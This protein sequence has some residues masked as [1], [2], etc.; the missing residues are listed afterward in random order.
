MFP[1]FMILPLWLIVAIAIPL[2]Q[3]L[4][5]LQ[6]KSAD[7]KTWLFYWICYVVATWLLYYF[8]WLI[9]IPFYVLS[10]YIDLYYEAQILLVL[11]LV[12][13]KFLGIRTLQTYLEQNAAI[14][15][16]VVKERVKDAAQV[17]YGKFNELK[18][19]IL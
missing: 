17:A 8:E 6:E 11:W 5:A 18:E 16:K 3:S 19:K 4:H 14:V 13:P 10:F 2:A 9:H 1:Y 15:D 12:F 7:R